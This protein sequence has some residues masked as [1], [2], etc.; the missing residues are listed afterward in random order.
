[1]KFCRMLN[2]RDS[3]SLRCSNYLWFLLFF[4]SNHH[5]QRKRNS[6][7]DANHAESDTRNSSSSTQNKKIIRS[8][9]QANDNSLTTN[10]NY[11]FIQYQ[12]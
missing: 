3:I 4:Q 9:F 5:N 2:M 12:S 8:E 10:R 1:M 11:S 7:I 6:F